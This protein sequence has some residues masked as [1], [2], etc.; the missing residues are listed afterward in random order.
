MESCRSTRR[1]SYLRKVSSCHD[2]AT[3]SLNRRS[4]AWRSFSRAILDSLRRCHLNPKMSTDLR[5]FFDEVRPAVDASLDLLL[6]S[7][8]TS[9]ERIH[10]AMRY[11]TLNG[12]K[13]V[14]PCLCVAAFG[15]YQHDWRP[16][17]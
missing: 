16:V 8:D 12:G 4:G 15:A 6:P 9:P 7:E 10:Q 13:R 1:W 5:A 3:R 11:S 2:S 17:L 14:R